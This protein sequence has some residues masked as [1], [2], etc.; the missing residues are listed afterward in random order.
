[1]LR[2]GPAG[3][4]LMQIAIEDLIEFSHF[5]INQT[6]ESAAGPAYLLLVNDMI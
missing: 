1:L 5:A 2:N 4:A 3:C 6:S